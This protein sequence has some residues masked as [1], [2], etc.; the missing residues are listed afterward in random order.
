MEN[1]YGIICKCIKL[2]ILHWVFTL[3]GLIS[4]PYYG[5]YFPALVPE[6]SF[7]A[8][9]IGAVFYTHETW[10]PVHLWHVPF[11]QRTGCEHRWLMDALWDCR[12]AAHR[13]RRGS[14]VKRAMCTAISL[15]VSACPPVCLSIIA[16]SLPPQ[17]L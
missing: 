17:P 2:C 3:S 14:H 13:T 6:T 4:G 16:G 9:G 7:S 8:G 1:I 12:V 10:T 11:G 5:R 15:S